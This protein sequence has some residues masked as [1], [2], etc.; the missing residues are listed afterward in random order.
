[1]GLR[2]QK[3]CWSSQVLKSWRSDQETGEEELFI[4]TRQQSRQKDFYRDLKSKFDRSST[5][6]ISVE[7]YKII[8]S[9]S[10]FRPTLK[11]LY[12]VSF[13][14]TLDIY[15]PYF[16]SRRACRK[17][18]S[19]LFS[20]KSYCVFTPRV[21]QPRSF[22]IFIVDELKELYSQQPLQVAGVSHILGSIHHWL[23]MYW[24]SC[25]ERKDCHYNTSPIGYWGKGSN[26]GWYFGISQRGQTRVRNISN[27][28]RKA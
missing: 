26:V 18:L 1:M 22:L 25:I 14:T 13:L 4:K 2:L 20:L 9:R 21:L 15:K 12:R 10:D 28:R 7:T 19:S 16:K 8:T 23:V 11:Y 24:D 3:T 17:C 27:R 6:A 5:Q